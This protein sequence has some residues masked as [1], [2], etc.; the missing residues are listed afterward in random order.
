MHK[1]K[2]RLGRASILLPIL[3][4]M[5]AVP[6]TP[7][8]ADTTS[9]NFNSLS[10]SA[11]VPN[12]FPTPSTSPSGQPN[13]A[14]GDWGSAGEWIVREDSV[15]HLKAAVPNTSVVGSA[16][17]Y[18]LIEQA[19]A[20]ANMD[21]SHGYTV[22]FQVLNTDSTN[23]TFTFWCGDQNGSWASVSD[24]VTAHSV[25]TYNS[26]F[27]YSCNESTRPL[28]WVAIQQTSGT[29]D[30]L[31]IYSLALTYTP[32]G[33]QLGTSAY[34][35]PQPIQVPKNYPVFEPFIADGGG[36]LNTFNVF[37]WNDQTGSDPG[38][39]YEFAL[40][41]TNGS[42][43]RPG[44]ILTWCLTGTIAYST[45]GV[46]YS[47][48]VQAPAQAV[49]LTTGNQYYLAMVDQ[50]SHAGTYN[51][52]L[53]GE[54][55]TSYSNNGMRGSTANSSLASPNPAIDTNW[56]DMG[57]HP[58]FYMSYG[59]PTNGILI[60]NDGQ[61]STT[62]I[63]IAGGQSG[64][65]NGLAGGHVGV[66]EQ[67]TA[68]ATGTAGHIWAYQN[69][70]SNG[71]NQMSVG[72]ASDSG[73]NTISNPPTTT[74]GECV[75]VGVLGFAWRSC[76]LSPSV[77]LTVGQKYWLYERAGDTN[78][79]SGG[80]VRQAACSNYDGGTGC[81]NWFGLAGLQFRNWC[82]T[83]PGPSWITPTQTGLGN[84]LVYATT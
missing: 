50:T 13:A 26:Q 55:W 3:V 27:T 11:H 54:D 1:W 42:N 51:T 63:T 62:A 65:T 71:A 25:Q 73:S 58:A 20:G 19:A 6:T 52:N 22:D 30:K 41:D 74:L 15:S 4:V 68:Q 39:Q 28:G 79:T 21:A 59:T 9:I 10:T 80:N 36:T 38:A 53:D 76:T 2:G 82:G 24:T 16:A 44:T 12:I 45:T 5:V 33:I 47:C 8:V 64:A 84:L 40:Y 81:T 32:S 43:G 31:G 69:T 34:S 67:F 14:W 77:S 78:G 29:A 23:D 56:P 35:E 75:Q 17:G 61:Q 7:A 46:T 60:G 48:T 66:A 72:I 57:R 49:S 18:M 37:M 70:P 83:C